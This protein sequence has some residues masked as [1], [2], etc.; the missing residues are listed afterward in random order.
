MNKYLSTL[1]IF[2]VFFTTA[3]HAASGK[4]FPGRKVYAHVPFI[5]IGD[6]FKKRK[7]VVVVDVRSK[8]EYQTLRVK[9]AKHISVGSTDF[10]KKVKQL[11]GQTKKP[12][13]FYCNVHTCFKSYKATD[14]SMA[15][16]IDNVL[17]FDAGIFD[18]TKA[19]PDQAVLLGQSPVD[20]RKL[21][22]KKS[23]KKRLLNPADFEKKVGPKVVVVDVRSRLQRKATGLFSFDEHWASMNDRKKLD[24]YIA[25]AKRERKP[26]L[27]YDSVGKQVR[28]LQYYLEKKGLKNYY[29]MKGGSENYYKMLFAKDGQSEIYK[30]VMVEGLRKKK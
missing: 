25:K 7:D 27:A 5:E 24:I 2:F 19:H 21:I 26:F 3:A 15:S 22:S 16:K 1:C 20:T 4:D 13:V 30:A 10:I 14:K 6:L 23:L 29:F 8:L 28:W 9:G 18:W 12:I 17:A 11:R